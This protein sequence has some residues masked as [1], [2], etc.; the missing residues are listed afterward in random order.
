MPDKLYRIML[1]SENEAEHCEFTKLTEG[2]EF[3]QLTGTT[4]YDECASYMRNTHFDVVICDLSLDS[5]A[6]CRLALYEQKLSNTEGFNPSQFIFYG[7]CANTALLMALCGE[8]RNN[9][10]KY[11]PEPYSIPALIEEAVSMISEKNSNPMS[12]QFIDN[13]SME[14]EAQISHILHDIGIPAH[15]KGYQYLRRAIIITVNEPDT[16]NYIT[17]ILYPSV[18]GY[19]DTTTSRVERA[20]RHAIEV[21]WDR[22]DIDVLNSYF[23]YTISRQRGKPTNSEFIA[24]IAD[25]LRLELKTSRAV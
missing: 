17:K 9:G 22:G 8:D 4:T 7:N 21:A 2:F 23:G 1:C 16:L 3:I 25:K 15:I 12:F 24:M 20:I 18:A 14:L 5:G 13:T 6:C 10:I 11:F 19:F